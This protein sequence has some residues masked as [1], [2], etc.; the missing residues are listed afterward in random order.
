[1]ERIII[2][3]DMNSCYASIECSLN[4]SL[5]GKPVA[6]GGSTED[7]HGIILAKSEEAKRC[8]IKT[9]EVIWQAQRKCPE[10]IVLPPRFEIYQKYSRMAGKI[11]YDYSDRVEPMGMDEAW[12]DL[13]GTA[14]DFFEAEKIVNEIKSRFKNELGITVSVGIS[15]NKIFAKLGSDLAGRDDHFIIT[16]E[17]FKEKIWNLPASSMMGVGR[18]TI[19]KLNQYGINTIGELASCSSKW[20]STV[21]GVTGADIWSYANGEDNSEVMKKGE[22]PPVKSVGHGITCKEDLTKEEQVWLVFLSLAQNVEKR[23][24]EEKMQATAVQIAIRNNQLSVRQF[25]CETPIATQSAFEIAKIAFS[26]FKKNYNWFHD[27]RALTIRAINL[28]PEDAP[29]QLLLYNDYEK[30]ERQKKIDDTVLNLKKRFGEKAVFNCCLM[31]E[32][33]MPVKQTEKAVPFMKNYKQ[34]GG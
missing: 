28:Q 8:G 22:Q 6:V 19:K 30:H 16:R 15:F 14:R 17:N 27:V 12:C 4:P 33:K 21:F 7:R 32:D 34:I 24:K 10:L 26:L 29:V 1:M 23:L 31:M 20:L 13:T 25:Q 11:Y 5:W 3:S 2:H 9:G 18:N